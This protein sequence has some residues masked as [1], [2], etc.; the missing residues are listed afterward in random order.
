[1][2]YLHIGLHKTGT[3]FLQQELFPKWKGI[4]Y[5]QEDKLEYL[6]RMNVEDVYLLSR[7]GLSGKNWMHADERSTCIRNL[8]TMLPEAR[9]ILSFR[10]HSGYIVSSYT[11]YLQQGGYLPFEE[12]FDMDHN[13]GFMKKEDFLFRRKIEDVQKYFDD[14]PFVILHEDIL[15]DLDGLIKRIQGFIGGEAPDIHSINRRSH[16]KSVGYYPAMA[17]R[18]LNKVSKSELNP[19]G[20]YDLYNWRFKRIGVDPR[21]LC[22]YRFNFFPKKSFI[23]DSLKDTIDHYYCDDWAYVCELGSDASK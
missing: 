6:T 16:N 18:R 2:L 13:R 8:S 12:Y 3:T 11:Q 1:V 7:E 9:I 17:L 10:K 22:Q 14:M 5:L 23:S 20:R 19:D 4:R 15:R 21:S